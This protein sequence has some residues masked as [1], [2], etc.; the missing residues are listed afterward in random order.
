[1]NFFNNMS[2]WYKKGR[3]QFSY[4]VIAFFEMMLYMTVP[5]ILV[6]VILALSQYGV[7]KVW[8]LFLAVIVYGLLMEILRRRLKSLY[9]VKS[10]NNEIRNRIEKY[11]SKNRKRKRGQAK[12]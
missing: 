6:I 1:M 10:I 9:T 7:L 12:M 2:E 5:L 11:N 4:G 3:K 8:M